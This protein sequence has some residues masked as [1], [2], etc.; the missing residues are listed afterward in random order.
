[1]G[2]GARYSLLNQA[3]DVRVFSVLECRSLEADV[4]TPV[5]KPEV[6]NHERENFSR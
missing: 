5:S 4:L 1:M 2:S 3:A 6:F